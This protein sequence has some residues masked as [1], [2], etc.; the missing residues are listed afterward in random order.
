MKTKNI[1][2]CVTGLTPQIVTETLYCLTVQKKKIIDELYII[3]TAKGRDIILGTDNEFNK[4]RGYPR[5]KSE[6]QK[7]C[8]K[9]R[10]N[11]PLFYENNEHIIVAKEQTIE[12]YDIRND[13][14]NI[15]FPNKVTEVLREKSANDE[16]VLYCSISGGR[17]TMSVDLAFALSLFGRTHDKLYH[18]L[19]DPSVEFNKDFW[20]PRNKKEQAFLEISEIPYIKLR[21]LLGEFT[22]NKLFK[23]LSYSKLVEMMQQLIKIKTSD[24][25]YIDVRRKEIRFGI[26]EPIRAEPRQIELYRYL[27]SSK[28]LGKNSL[29][30]KDL[31]KY[32]YNTYES[33]NVLSLISKLNSNISLAIKDNSIENIFKICGPKEFGSGQYGILADVDKIVFID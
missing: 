16:N 14:H 33:K 32:F 1:L 6:L 17:K 28:N 19:V 3:T 9:Y 25:L 29:Y 24:K 5:F 2:I 4:E 18:V 20:F 7:L 15:L 13:K 8:E 27:I 21:T 30:I 23:N 12:L 31:A 10:I 11:I 26:N 22:K